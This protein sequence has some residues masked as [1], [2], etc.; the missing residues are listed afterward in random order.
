[1]STIIFITG[2]ARSGKSSYAQKRA[3]TI[4]GQKI[5]VATCPKQTDD[6]EMQTR[7]DLHAKARENRGW[8]TIEEPLY[9]HEIIKANRKAKVLLVDCLTLWISNLMEKCGGEAIQESGVEERC[10]AVLAAAESI[11]GTIFFVS[12]EVGLG[13]VPENPLA[14]HFRDL[15]GR[16]NQIMAGRAHEVVLVSCGLPLYLKKMNNNEAY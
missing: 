10:L 12:N 13:I 5:F 14:R 1:M 7:I 6:Q 3:E 15:V 9:L 11:P 2:G 4:S 8:T 16:C